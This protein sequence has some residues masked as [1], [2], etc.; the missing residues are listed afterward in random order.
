M[1]VW[2]LYLF[3]GLLCIINF[4]VGDLWEVIVEFF[5]VIVEVV[6]CILECIFFE[7]VV[8]IVDCGIMFVGGGVLV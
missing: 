8:D 7:L 5:N 2:G 3:F 4:K 6:K 1:D